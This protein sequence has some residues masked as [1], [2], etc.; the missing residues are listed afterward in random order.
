MVHAIPP[1]LEGT[2]NNTLLCAAFS[3]ACERLIYVRALLEDP[4]HQTRRQGS[5]VVRLLREGLRSAERALQAVR[6]AAFGQADDSQ[7]V[8]TLA[9]VGMAVAGLR[10]VHACLGYLGTRWPLGTADLFVRKLL[11]EGMPLPTP[12]LCPT[13]HAA[14]GAVEVGTNLRARL[15]AIGLATEAP[16][17]G[18]PVL[19]LPTMDLLDPLSWA[20]LL[21]PLAGAVV[22][23]RGMAAQL[24]DPA[25]LDDQGGYRRACIAGLAARLVG[26]ATYAACATRGLLAR[27]SGGADTAD[28]HMLASATTA[29]ARP[30]GPTGPETLAGYYA[31]LLE[32]QAALHAGWGRVERHAPDPDGAAPPELSEFARAGIPAPELPSPEQVEALVEQLRDGRPINAAPPGLPAD[33]ADQLASGADP[34]RF[35][36]LLPHVDE[37]PSSLAAILAAG[38]RY[39]VRYSY[40]LC[41]T[42][43]GGTMTWRAALD[44]LTAH[45]LERCALLQQSIEAAYVQQVFAR[46]RDR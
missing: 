11:A 1:S 23:A 45:V 3:E 15:D 5:A 17:S 10:Q 18:A 42:V 40:L 29:Y 41:A 34:E 9:G 22:D 24:H 21:V 33:F 12:T 4:R 27:L 46:W 31:G 36:A 2:T 38:W 35:Y 14:D 13:D 28:L 30:L 37:R 16:L 7:T 43:M 8:A 39:K 19:T 44:T 26:E 6:P 32:A 25:S 20:A